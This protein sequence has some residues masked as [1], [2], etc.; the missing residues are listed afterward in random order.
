M[1]L[2]HNVMRYE[3]LQPQ[4]FSMRWVAPVV[5]WLNRVRQ[6]VPGGCF[7]FWGG[8]LTHADDIHA[9]P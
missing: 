3:A 8:A 7:H 4:A 1:G 9:K 2:V 6:L 5:E